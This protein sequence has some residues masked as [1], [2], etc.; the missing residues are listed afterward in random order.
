MPRKYGWPPPS[1]PNFTGPIDIGE[2]TL[3]DPQGNRL[4]T[5]VLT[6]PITIN[7]GQVLLLSLILEYLGNGLSATAQP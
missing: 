4:S 3:N 1:T 6:D 7:P 5:W 2:I